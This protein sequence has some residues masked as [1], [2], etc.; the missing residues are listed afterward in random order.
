MDAIRRLLVEGEAAITCRH[1]SGRRPILFFLFFEN[2][3][4]YQSEWKHMII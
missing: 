2:W 4:G 1:D 3:Y